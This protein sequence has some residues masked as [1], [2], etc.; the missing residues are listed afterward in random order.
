MGTGQR[1]CSVKVEEHKLLELKLS[2]VHLAIK[3]KGKA[4]PV[5]DNE[6]P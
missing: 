3:G 2:V 1:Y 4:I 6:G 5:T